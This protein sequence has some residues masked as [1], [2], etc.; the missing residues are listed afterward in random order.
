MLLASLEFLCQSLLFSTLLTPVTSKPV[1]HKHHG[2][3]E[4]QA[5]AAAAAPAAPE[6]ISTADLQTAAKVDGNTKPEIVPAGT[7]LSLSQTSLTTPSGQQ[8]LSLPIES[9]VLTKVMMDVAGAS[10]NWT[11]YPGQTFTNFQQ[12]VTGTSW[13]FVA[14]SASS[15]EVPYA[16]LTPILNLFFRRANAIDKKTTPLTST[17]VGSVAS[18]NSTDPIAY[19]LFLPN[20][21]YSGLGDEGKQVGHEF[22]QANDK[23][24][25]QNSPVK[26]L[27]AA[28]GGS[29]EVEQPAKTANDWLASLSDD[30][31]IAAPLG[32][33]TW[34]MQLGLWRNDKNQIVSGPLSRLTNVAYGASE[35]GW[36]RALEGNNTEGLTPV[37]GD[38]VTWYNFHNVAARLT[39]SIA[40]N[41]SDNLV[42]EAGEA[43]TAMSQALYEALK[44]GDQVNELGYAMTGKFSVQTEHTQVGGNGAP[45]DVQVGTWTLAVFPVLSEEAFA[46][47]HGGE[48]T[49]AGNGNVGFTTSNGV[50]ATNGLDT[51][52]GQDATVTGP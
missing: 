12:N 11:L 17:Y 8:L 10:F 38:S 37:T 27:T 44:K 46:A 5:A 35:R 26:V 6:V 43:I 45:A 48:Q 42:G 33:A 13:T 29:G 4:R 34:K 50:D 7:T 22:G 18:A 30:R 15:A 47:L 23:V 1:Y 49:T 28:D 3:F 9:E 36:L 40:D 14:I 25:D 16:I 21:D 20:S 52:N 2:I 51:T 19:V 41:G 24:P 32:T 39:F 31:T